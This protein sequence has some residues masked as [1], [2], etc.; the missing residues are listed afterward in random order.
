MCVIDSFAFS[1]FNMS[2]SITISGFTIVRNALLYDFPVKESILSA[3]DFV[4]EFIVVLG[5]SDD[6][7]EALIKSIDSPKIKIIY[8][9]W[10]VEKYKSGGMVYAH[11]T[12]IA[13]QA[14]SGEWCLYLQADEVLHEDAIPIIENACNYYKDNK[15]V[16][17]FLLKYIHFYGYYDSYIDALHFAY[18]KEIRIVRNRIDIHSWGDA[19]SFRIISSF[20]YNNYWQKENTQKLNC[21]LLDA[22]IY[23]Y[24]W[25]RDPRKMTR[26]INE[27][28]SLTVGEL[29]QQV[30]PAMFDYG[31][32]A[33][34]TTFKGSHPLVMQSR[35]ESTDWKQFL[36]YTGERPRGL[37][38]KFKLKYRILSFIENKILGGRMI[39]GFKNYK[40]IGRYPTKNATGRKS[41]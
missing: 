21:I 35:I 29:H 13:L 33:T 15:E 17:G 28:H 6:D 34:L 1:K 3:L 23:H 24:G 19:Q 41:F 37:A 38:K 14:C 26:K 7:T 25:C 16:D 8:S 36:R 22:Y 2:S 32:L 9:H 20:D 27:Q 12:D 5:D 39:A 4:E 31:N 30:Q 10:D 40:Q 18:P 11:Q